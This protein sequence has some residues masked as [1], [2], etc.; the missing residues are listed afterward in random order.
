MLQGILLYSYS[1][2]VQ[3]LYDKEYL[4]YICIIVFTYFCII[5]LL[6]KDFNFLFIVL[7]FFVNI[8]K[9]SMLSQKHMVLDQCLS[10]SYNSTCYPGLFQKHVV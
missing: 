8:N 10:L 3:I 2:K 5:S 1:Y 9:A 6:I 4:D 7:I